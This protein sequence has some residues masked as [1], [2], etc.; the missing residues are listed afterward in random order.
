M[1]NTTNFETAIDKKALEYQENPD[2]LKQL[3]RE[4]REMVNEIKKS[5]LIFS[6]PYIEDERFKKEREK[7]KK[8]K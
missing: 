5:D 8:R 4:Y 7:R 6:F 2:L 1:K 3:R